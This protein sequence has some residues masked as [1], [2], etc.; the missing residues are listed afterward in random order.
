MCESPR[1]DLSHAQI[2]MSKLE[3]AA[4]CRAFESIL[5]P[6]PLYPSLSPYSSL[7]LS[8]SFFL[9][10]FLSSS[11]P[12]FLS[13]SLPLSL[14]PSLPL[15]LTPSLPLCSCLFSLLL[16]DAAGSC[17]RRRAA[18]AQEGARRG[19]IPCDGSGSPP[20]AGARAGVTRRPVLTFR[21]PRSRDGRRVR[22]PRTR[23]AAD[24]R[25][26]RKQRPG[27]LPS[28]GRVICAVMRVHARVRMRVALLCTMNTGRASE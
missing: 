9:S 22:A 14:S 15:P 18:G 8:F 19:V 6:S 28:A 16:S 7:P 27:L 10:S 26:W 23:M 20:Y 3:L 13:S 11:L 1:E 17:G 25:G 2:F 4:F 21:M 24:E 12:L 5:S